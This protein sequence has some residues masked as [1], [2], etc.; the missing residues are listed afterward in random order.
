MSKTLEIGFFIVWT[1]V[2]VLVS[3]WLGQASYSWM[4]PQATAEAQ[5]IDSL[6]SFLV[7]L[8]AV[9]FFAIFGM[10]G[11]SILVCRAPVGD[12]SEGHPSRGNGW[13][14]LLWTG[15][16]VV[17]VLWIA[18]QG[19]HVYDLLDL[20]GLS[21]IARPSGNS[22]LAAQKT[23]A[24][25]A[26]IETIEVTVKQWAW[27]FH[28]P[29]QNIT[30]ATLHLPAH[31]RVR[32]ALKSEDVLHGFYVPAFRIKQDIIPNQDISLVISPTLEGQYR[33]SDSQFS[34]AYFALM[35]ADVL[36]DS[37]A[38]YQQ[39]LAQGG[40]QSTLNAEQ[41]FDWVTADLSA[42]EQADPPNLWGHHWAVKTLSPLQRAAMRAA[43]SPADT[44]AKNASKSSSEK[45]SKNSSENLSKT[46]SENPIKKS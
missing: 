7:T 16:P 19:L 21:A 8:G 15:I 10:I 26:T 5:Q 33:L 2:T 4:P 24:P 25:A 30:S 32:L 13:L 12:F 40:P 11:H 44:F 14:E 29:K 27:A 42:S 37:P 36:V 1:A 35:E 43:P 6:F 46:L 39:W 3:Y 34:G 31:Q 38:D 18:V 45:P 41:N 22:A 9:V 28:Y 20:E 17:L 23:A